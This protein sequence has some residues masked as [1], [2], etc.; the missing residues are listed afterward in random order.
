MPIVDPNT[1]NVDARYV[2]NLTINIIYQTGST[3]NAAPPQTQVSQTSTPNPL[4]G[5]GPMSD[6]AAV[7]IHSAEEVAAAK[8][9]VALGC[10]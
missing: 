8:A 1:P 10:H 9:L 4:E 7:N 5:G 2:Q 6:L 3:F